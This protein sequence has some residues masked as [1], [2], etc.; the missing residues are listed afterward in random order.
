MQRIHLPRSLFR[1]ALLVVVALGVLLQ[2]LLADMGELHD[3]EHSIAMQSDHGHA[4]HDGHDDPADGDEVP[5]EPIGTHNLLHQ[6]GF[7]VSA[8][9]FEPS[10]YLVSPVPA[11]DPPASFH[12][13]APPIAPLTLPFRPP[14]T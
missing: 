13:T 7:A 12:S 14:I 1:Y 10:F 11:G 8:A 2:P 9:L 6:G 5:G 4:H 3:V